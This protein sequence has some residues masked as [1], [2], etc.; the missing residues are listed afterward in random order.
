MLM[1]FVIQSVSTVSV[2]QDL[3]GKFCHSCKITVMFRQLG[4][5]SVVI[6]T[7]GFSLSPVSKQRDNVVGQT[8]LAAGPA[9]LSF[10]GATFF[11]R[12][13]LCSKDLPVLQR[14]AGVGGEEGVVH[15]SNLCSAGYMLSNYDYS[16]E[17]N[18]RRQLQ[19]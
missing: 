11:Q 2:R 5:V 17:K 18:R 12:A 15:P 13:P 7:P 19:C 8:V 3:P 4:F 9:G 14:D 16:G 1:R 6:Q 10:R